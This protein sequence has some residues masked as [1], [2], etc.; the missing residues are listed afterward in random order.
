MEEHCRASCRVCDPD[1][2]DLGLPQHSDDDTKVL[3]DEIMAKT[4]VYMEQVATDAF[5]SKALA[6]CKNKHESCAYWAALGEVS[7]TF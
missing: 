5:L 1:A 6:G 7:A 2:L 3:V 4:K